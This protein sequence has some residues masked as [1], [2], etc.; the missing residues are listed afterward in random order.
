MSKV[1]DD[2]EVLYEKGELI[3]K[4]SFGA[5]Y[6]GRN[7]KT[8]E[9]VAIK[10]IDLEEAEDEIEDI[11][12]EISALSQVDCPFVT[13]Y[14]GSYL[15]DAKLW[16]IMEFL[17][18]GSV[19]DL[20]KPE[21]GR[22]EE[23]YIA[24]IL[25]EL[26]RALEYLHGQG[27]LHRDIKAANILLSTTGDVRL[28]DFGVSGQISDQMQKRNTF[29]GTPFWMAPEVIKQAGYD[30]KAD[31]WSL[32]VTAIEMAKG[33]PP[34]ADLHPMRVLFL[35]PKNP[36]PELD[37]SFS[38]PFREFVAECLQ[39]EPEKRPTAH[40]LLKHK[41]IKG[42]KKTSVLLELIQRHEAWLHDKQS[43][44]PDDVDDA[45]EETGAPEGGSGWNFDGIQSTV[46]A[47]RGQT[48]MPSGSFDEDSSSSPAP[49]APLK[50]DKERPSSSHGHTHSHGNGSDG[51]RLS[52][53]EKDRDAVKEARSQAPKEAPAPQAAKPEKPEKP[54]KSPALNSVV[55]PVLAKLLQQNREDPNVVA[56]LS[57]LKIAFDK[58]EGAEAGLVHQFITKMIDTLQHQQHK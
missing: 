7:R 52:H 37:A 33:E 27:R 43:S 58:S 21:P 3:G 44:R 23:G 6:K 45:V 13:R 30:F 56:V 36:P 14:Y 28:A 39:K 51:K 46:K 18:G 34:Y 24:V 41:F 55:Y 2:P 49:M 42:A 50:K 9:V 11:H 19:L 25:R 20:M 54:E 26:L 22:L 17:G 57:Q 29:V 31:I 15:K 8:G 5:V 53:K 16:I 12:Q 38:K 47:P 40:D 4:G 48:V 35:I 1:R 10:V 32:G